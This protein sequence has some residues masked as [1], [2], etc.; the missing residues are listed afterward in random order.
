MSDNGKKDLHAIILTL[1]GVAAL[2]VFFRFFSDDLKIGTPQ[3]AV[4]VVVSQEDRGKRFAKNCTACHDLTRAKRANLVGPPLWGLF[5]QPA[6]SVAG[7][8]YSRAHIQA[9]QA[10]LV[11]NEENL[12]FYLTNPKAFIPGNRMAFAGV[13]VDEERWALLAYLKTL[14]DKDP[15]RREPLPLIEQAQFFFTD[16]Q[17]SSSFEAR[18]KRGKIVAEKCAACHDLN[19]SRKIIVGPPLFGIVG[20]PAGDVVTFKYSPALQKKSTDGMVWTTKKLNQ[21]LTNPQVYI[22][23]TKMLFAGISNPKQR[24]D[25]LTYLRTLK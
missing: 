7:Y 25:L 21:F 19:E 1:V 4:S 10:G 8:K 13:K 6:G 18:V 3:Q 20:R 15:V 23:E 22:P 11:W 5:D 14:Q 17:D 2:V 24:A 16:A 9:A 12:D